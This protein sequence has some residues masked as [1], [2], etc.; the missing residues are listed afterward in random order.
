MRKQ[1]VLIVASA[2]V[3]EACTLWVGRGNSSVLL[4]AMF[5]VWVSAPFVAT[6]AASLRLEVPL[7]ALSFVAVISP[8]VYILASAGALPAP[9]A[10]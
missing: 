4:I 6:L 10:A 5:V 7:W 9:P 8:I 1:D 2:V 3:C